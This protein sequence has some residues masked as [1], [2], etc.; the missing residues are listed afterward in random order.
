MIPKRIVIIGG[1]ITGLAAAYHLKTQAQK[2]SLPLDL[3]L[4][5]ASQ[6]FG[7]SLQTI[8]R[9]GFLLE[10]GPDCFISDKPRGIGL[11]RELGLEEELIGTQPG[12]RRSFILRRGEL[13]RV[14]EGFYLLGPA[15]LRPFLASPVLSWRGKCRVLAEPLIPKRTWPKK[16]TY[17]LLGPGPKNEYI[18]PA[19]PPT[20]GRDETLASFV[21]R[22]LGRE[23]LDYM[24]QPLLGGIFA[25]DPE[26]LSLQATFPQFLQMEE[27]YG[28]V[29]LGL[30]L[31]TPRAAQKA[32][33]ARYSL[34]VSLKRGMQTLVDR[35]EK[36]LGGSVLQKGCRV[37]GIQR[38]PSHWQITLTNGRALQADGIILAL[39]AF[40]SA[41]FVRPLHAELA[42]LLTSIPYHSAIT[43]NLAFRRVDIAHPLDGVGFV[44]PS[45]EQRTVLACTFSHRKFADRAPEGHAL[46]RAFL[47]GASF[48]VQ[49]MSEAELEKAVLADLGKILGINA[50]PLFSLVQRWPNAMPQYTLGHIHR[51]LQI[52]ESALGLKGLALAGNWGWGVGIPDCI[53]SGERAAENLLNQTN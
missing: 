48:A 47:G 4:L 31:R 15:K 42:E 6:R 50:P 32:S 28:S 33:G 9:D 23:V 18:A 11:C 7:G 44:V 22:R 24:A 53:E 49:D 35:L 30:K 45:T 26:A 34:F 8:S 1:G 19:G 10:G 20:A 17:S 40:A 41:E 13:H 2:Q 14:P 16:S 27:K 3:R 38:M 25:A 39:P 36:A 52:E 51:L 29:L 43:V 5:E 12:Y 37:Q 46:L 21:R